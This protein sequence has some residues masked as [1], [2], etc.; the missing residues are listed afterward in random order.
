VHQDHRTEPHRQRRPSDFPITRAERNGSFL[1]TSNL[2]LAR[3]C[4]S[5]CTIG[6]KIR[7]SFQCV[8]KRCSWATS[9]PLS[10]SANTSHSAI[11]IQQCSPCTSRRYRPHKYQSTDTGGLGGQDD[12]W[13]APVTLLRVIRDVVPSVLIYRAW[14][15]EVLV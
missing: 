4:R 7:G 12:A 13:D 15:D 5:F 6:Y 8:F 10:A 2:V 3:S 9:P 14:V 1:K 11:R